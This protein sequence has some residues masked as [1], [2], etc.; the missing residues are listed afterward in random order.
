MEEKKKTKLQ[1]NC[2]FHLEI[3]FLTQDED[4]FGTC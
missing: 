4:V 3:I 2:V 1:A